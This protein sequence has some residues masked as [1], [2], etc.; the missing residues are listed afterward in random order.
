MDRYEIVGPI[1]QGAYGIVLRG[2]IR[3][4]GKIV[5][6]KKMTITSRNQLQI[7]RELC[8]LRNLHHSKV[9]KLID[10]FC[11]R[12]SLSLVTEFVAFHL[13]DVITDPGRPHCDEFLR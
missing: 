3:E 2:K 5:A 9:L 7:L 4:S 13:N 11:S 1:G 8:S 6:I 10:V 12:D